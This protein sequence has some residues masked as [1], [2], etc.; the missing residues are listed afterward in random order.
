ML[1]MHLV[2]NLKKIKIYICASFV[3]QSPRTMVWILGGVGMGKPTS[4]GL[5][6]KVTCSTIKQENPG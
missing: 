5:K 1:C 3:F 2:S 4:E 6:A